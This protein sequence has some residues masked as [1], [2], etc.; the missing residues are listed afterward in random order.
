[1]RLRRF[2]RYL[3]G[4]RRAVAAALPKSW[5]PL[6]Q[7]RICRLPAPWRPPLAGMATDASAPPPLARQWQRPSEQAALLHQNARPSLLRQLPAPGRSRLVRPAAAGAATQRA[8]A[9]AEPSTAAASA[10]SP[11]AT[12]AAASAASDAA[13][14]S[15]YELGPPR[16]HVRFCL[17]IPNVASATLDDVRAGKVQ[18]G[19]NNEAER[20][21]NDWSRKMTPQKARTPPFF[22]QSGA[23]SGRTGV[24]IEC[25]SASAF[26]VSAISAIVQSSEIAL[27]CVIPLWR[28]IE[29]RYSDGSR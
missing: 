21:C 18:H 17:S 23:R 27:L 7:A 11:I 5:A 22:Y 14:W 4:R 15:F 25:R 26:T 24:P 13:S 16:R 12:A 20:P 10:A 9:S 6:Q 28:Q 8:V 2:R 19:C 29:S 1:M 3:A